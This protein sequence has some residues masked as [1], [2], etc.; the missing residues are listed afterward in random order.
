ML[1]NL[2][3]VS[4]SGCAALQRGSRALSSAVPRTPEEIKQDLERAEKMTRFL[5][6]PGSFLTHPLALFICMKYSGGKR[7]VPNI[8]HFHCGDDVDN[9]FLC[10][11]CVRVSVCLYFTTTFTSPSNI[12]L[13]CLSEYADAYGCRKWRGSAHTQGY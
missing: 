7:I 1:A 13:S 3:V 6:K 9:L 12:L 10:V 11:L 4:R 5:Q 8:L 2:T